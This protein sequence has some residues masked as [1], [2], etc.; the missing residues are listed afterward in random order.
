MKQKSCYSRLSSIECEW[1]NLSGEDLRAISEVPAT[2]R[3]E[4]FQLVVSLKQK[5]R[6]ISNF[7][8]PSIWNGN[9]CGIGPVL[10]T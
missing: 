9:V 5:K 6:E 4:C 10:M 1:K 8:G 7:M 2:N 3:Q